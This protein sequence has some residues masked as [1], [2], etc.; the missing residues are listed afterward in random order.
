MA[1]LIGSAAPLHR[2]VMG[3]ALGAG[4]L[5]LTFLTLAAP[6]VMDALPLAVR[7]LMTFVPAAIWVWRQLPAHAPHV[8]WGWANHVTAGRGC[9]LLIWLVWGWEQPV[10]GWESVALG[11]AFLLADGL[12]G[13]IAR[14]Q[15]TAS[16]FGARFDLEVD[17][18]FVLVAGLLLLRTGQVGAW[19][20]ISG[21][22]RYGYL[23]A[24]R[25]QPALSRALPPSRRRAVFGVTNAAL[26]TA[27]FAPV[28]SAAWV[29]AMAG[30]GLT[31]VLLSFLI[32]MGALQAR[33]RKIIPD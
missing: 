3:S 21:L 2:E 27:G 13:T 10:L 14:R 5:A 32:D 29:Q 30:V 28:F 4:V 19:V 20:L 31:L 17:A 33:S 12:D 18:L 6:T 11:T 1:N 25:W 23:L 24:G 8:H 26:L 22:L 9:V 7:F 15:G 16:P